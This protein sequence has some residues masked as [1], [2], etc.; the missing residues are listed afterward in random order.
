[1]LA[2][3]P[4]LP[5][6]WLVAVLPLLAVARGV[7]RR[8]PPV[9]RPSPAAAHSLLGTA[10]ASPQVTGFLNLADALRELC[11]QRLVQRLAD[12]E[13]GA[14]LAEYHEDPAAQDIAWGTVR[15]YGII[16][17]GIQ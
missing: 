17:T 9:L 10:P 2:L 7:R 5:R 6:A 15:C 13:L 8:H 14:A 12:L 16:D 3:A 1:M 11:F 4:C